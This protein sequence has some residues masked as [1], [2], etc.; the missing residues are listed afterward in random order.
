MTAA[1]A[2]TTPTPTPI[3]AAEPSAAQSLFGQAEAL[4]ANLSRL[5]AQEFALNLGLSAAVLVGAALIIWL[6]R[7]ALTAGLTRMASKG[8]ARHAEDE[9]KPQVARWTWL[10]IRLAVLAGAGVLV[11]G[12]WGLDLVRW[13]TAGEGVAVTRIVVVLLIA[14]AA[15]EIVG[16]LMS[17]L[18]RRF[19]ARAKDPRRAQQVETLA[20]LLRG[21]VQGFIVVVAGLTLLSE[22]GVQIAPLLASAGVVGVAVGFG[23]QTIVKDVLTGLFLVLEDIVSVGDNVTIGDGVAIGES[24]GTVEA[25]T[26]RTIRLRAANGTLHVFPYGEAQVIHNHTKTFSAYLFEIPVD[27][28]ADV[29]QALA[30][31]ARVGAEMR[32][33]PAWREQVTGELEVMGVDKLTAS[34]IVLKARFKTPPRAQWDVGREYHR[35]LKI[36][37]QAA[38]IPSPFTWTKIANDPPVAADTADQLD[39]QRGHAAA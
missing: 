21:V 14:A 11:L 17:R 36:A 29:D 8:L 19:E 2:P 26:L 35:R 6:L 28:R 24:Q 38:G 23:A 5:T 10:L 4:W 7:R 31:M 32:A 18:T 37:F 3:A 33:D 13:L 1:A 39:D 20:P 16:H 12:I 9:A 27:F 15:V 30:E 34:E 22:F 25:M